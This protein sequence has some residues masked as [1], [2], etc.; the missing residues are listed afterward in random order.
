MGI[1]GLTNHLSRARYALRLAFTEDHPPKFIAVSFAIGV[2]VTTLPT[3]GIGIPLLAW[4]GYRFEWANRLA[5]FAAVVILNPLVKSGVYV[6]SLLIGVQLLGPLPGNTPI[7]LEV[8]VG[9]SVLVRL[10]VGNA[11]LAI[12]FTIVGYLVAYRTAHAVRLR[13]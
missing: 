7:E 6:L 10:L 5:L 8:D 13:R 1:S 4:I 2:F 12:A 9:A 11:V 3:F